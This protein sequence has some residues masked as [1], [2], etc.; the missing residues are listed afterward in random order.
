MFACPVQ[1]IC[2]QM[3]CLAKTSG[4]WTG[5]ASVTGILF[6]SSLLMSCP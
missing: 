1:T 6:C 5:L 4:V 2:S 3:A